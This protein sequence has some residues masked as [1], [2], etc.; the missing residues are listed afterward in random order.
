MV[1]LAGRQTAKYSEDKQ[2][3]PGAKQVFRFPDHDILACS[4]ECHGCDS[5]ETVALQRPVILGGQLVEPLPTIQTSRAAAAENIS[6]LPLATRSLFDND[7]KYRVEY[8][9]ELQSL[10]VD[11]RASLRCPEVVK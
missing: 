4:W 6:R 5:G 11:V 9:R 2:T 3:I 1:E 10:M 7:Q 8:S